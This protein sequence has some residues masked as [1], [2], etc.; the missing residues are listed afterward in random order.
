MGDRTVRIVLTS[1]NINFPR[2][3]DIPIYRE[4]SADSGSFADGTGPYRP[5]E[6]DN[7]WTLEANENWHG[8]S[9]ARSGT[10]HLCRSRGRTRPCPSFQTGDVSLMR[11]ARIDPDPPNVGGSVDTVQTAARRCTI[12]ALIMTIPC[13]QTPVCGAR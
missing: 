6:G 1:P 12:W 4:G 11:A 13:W 8:A 10:S 3:L 7:G 9:S 2:L 5:V